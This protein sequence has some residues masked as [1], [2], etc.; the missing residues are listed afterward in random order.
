MRIEEFE[1]ALDQYGAN[2][3]EWPSALA[4]QARL[5]LASSL[6]ARELLE[7][8]AM[9]AG[10]LGAQ[11]KAPSGMADR[12]F[13]RAFGEEEILPIA[14]AAP[15]RGHPQVTRSWWEAMSGYMQ[16]LAGQTAIRYATVLAICFVGGFAVAQVTAQ[17]KD[18]PAPT[19]VSGLYADL[20][21]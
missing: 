14:A 16:A 10:S 11:V 6:D 3:E 17:D 15:V 7:V 20:A 1:D 4:E 13:S 19:Y 21:W 2:I 5:L 9:I 8:E 18:I 12:L